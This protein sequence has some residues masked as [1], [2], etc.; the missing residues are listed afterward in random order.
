VS[1]IAAD[2]CDYTSTACTHDIHSECRRTCKWCEAPCG[3]ECHVEGTMTNLIAGSSL[4]TPGSERRRAGVP[5]AMVEELM[6]RLKEG[7]GDD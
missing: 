3:C 7:E 6:R 5:K 4:G 1:P 2:P